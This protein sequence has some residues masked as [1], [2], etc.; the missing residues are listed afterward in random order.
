MIDKAVPSNIK[1]SVK[2]T[3]PPSFITDKTNEEKIPNCLLHPLSDKF[4]TLLVK[5][6]NVT[7]ARQDPIVLVEKLSII[8]AL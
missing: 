4:L 5:I 7:Q 3:F 8:Q 6:N 2:I 1:M